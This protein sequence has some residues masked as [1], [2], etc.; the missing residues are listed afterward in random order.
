M[1]LRN[2]YPRKLKRSIRYDVKINVDGKSVFVGRFNSRI[3]AI[4]A[5]NRDEGGKTITCSGCGKETVQGNHT[6]TYC[7]PCYN[8]RQKRPSVDLDYEFLREGKAI[9]PKQ[10]ISMSWKGAT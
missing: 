7:R 4:D 1:N 9:T 5:R 6:G 8:N 10:L 3:E 2:I